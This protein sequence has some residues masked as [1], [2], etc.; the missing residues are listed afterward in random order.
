MARLVW[1]LFIFLFS[2]TLSA[3]E[4]H[5][6]SAEVRGL[7]G[8]GG[9]QHA[10][11]DKAKFLQK[12]GHN[13]KL[14][15]PFYTVIDESG[16][17]DFK[18]V[19]KDLRATF[20]NG[21]AIFT[22]D[23]VEFAHPENPELKVLAMKHNPGD[24]FANIF[25]NITTDGS[26]IYSHHPHEGE[27]FG[28][29][30]KQYRNYLDSIPYNL[31]PEVVILN[32][33]H[34]G[35][36]GAYLTEREDFFK[37]QVKNG[38][39]S[40]KAKKLPKVQ[41]VVHN[42]KYQGVF[43]HDFFNWLGINERYFNS[44]DMHGNI[45]YLKSL[46]VNSDYVETVSMQYA[47]EITTE[48]FGEGLHY[49]TRDLAKRGKLSGLLNGI[50]P[51]KWNPNKPNIDDPDFKRLGFSSED[52]LKEANNKR[53]GKERLV[54]SLFNEAPTDNTMVMALTAR[55]DNQKGFAYLLGEEGLLN[56]VLS[57]NSIDLKIVLAGDPHGPREQSPL[58]QELEELQRKYPKKISI[59]KFTPELERKFLYY[60]DFYFGGSVFEP[61]GLAQM[62]SQSVGT[63]PIVSRLGGHVDSVIDGESGLLFD[64]VKR[65]GQINVNQTA[66]NAHDAIKKAS[67][68]MKNKNKFYKLRS[69]VSQIDNSWGKRVAY[70]EK[71]LDLASINAFNN[72]KLFNGNGPV[73]LSKIH[74]K[75]HAQGK[76]C[77]RAF[78]FLP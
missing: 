48:E 56:R 38:S 27:V 25:D 22:Y 20:N 6:L 74:A 2:S 55:V 29:F 24:G 50:D 37:I 41:G 53:V 62:F 32:D 51:E 71:F 11:L 54:Q 69:Y 16:L 72:P 19:S 40:S 1:F 4:I 73:N 28:V 70:F 18:V 34:T 63:V 59:N 43:G 5:I 68:L 10:V 26:K 23:V 8:T 67:E 76:F 9:L 36:A 44:L 31:Q 39:I 78:S 17:D 42:M 35:M 7:H 66:S 14:V 52:L 77:F 13:V 57:D 64:V 3:E 58:I 21:G 65:D 75:M 15:M 33:W 49:I 46:M 61:S 30:G 60:A 45:N 47:K 12:N